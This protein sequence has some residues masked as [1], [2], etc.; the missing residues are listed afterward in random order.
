MSLSDFCDTKAST[1]G[2]RLIKVK[3]EEEEE[4]RGLLS[5]QHLKYLLLTITMPLREKE[6]GN[7]ENYAPGKKAQP[8]RGNNC[9]VCLR[10]QNQ[11]QLRTRSLGL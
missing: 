4:Q 7:K 11:E 6:I 3:K 8:Q 9:S 1:P 10:R 2:G 5:P